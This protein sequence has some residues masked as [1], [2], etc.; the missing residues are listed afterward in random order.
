MAPILTLVRVDILFV[1]AVMECQGYR[2]VA[3]LSVALLGQII[4]SQAKVQKRL[5]CISSAGTILAR[6]GGLHFPVERLVDDTI[7]AMFAANLGLL[8]VSVSLV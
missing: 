8:P 7:A 3:K 2:G 1:Q 5:H 4:E 6:R